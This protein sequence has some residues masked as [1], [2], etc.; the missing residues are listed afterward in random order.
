MCILHV[1][2]KLLI[3]ND[4]VTRVYGNVLKV[5]WHQSGA[6]MLEQPEST[7]NSTFPTMVSREDG[8]GKD[9]SSPAEDRCKNGFSP[10]FIL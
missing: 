8:K 3:Q 7:D 1:L 10:E 2:D 4:I 6:G 5:E 9:V